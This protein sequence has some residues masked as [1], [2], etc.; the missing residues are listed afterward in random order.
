MADIEGIKTGEL[1]FLNRAKNLSSKYKVPLLGSELSEI[2]IY[3]DNPTTLCFGSE[4]LVNTFNKGKF[5]SRIT[6]FQNESLL[7]KAFALQLTKPKKILDTTGG[8]GHDA[9]ILALLGQKVTVVE[10]NKGLCILLEEALNQLPDLSYFNDAANNITINNDDS[11]TFLDSANDFDVIYID[12]MFNSNKKL[13]RTK[14]MEFLDQYLHE[15]DNPSV[16]FFKSDFKRLVI[17][18]EL[19][20]PASIKDS[21]AISFKGSSIRYDVYIKE[22]N[23][24]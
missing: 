13:K 3:L 18:K 12:P 11:R 23:E 7:K 14:Q 16:D 5:Y 22:K 20:A 15:Y 1:N 19:R 10:K 2:Y 4:K 21:S 6:K 24:F 8:L 9:F 17:K